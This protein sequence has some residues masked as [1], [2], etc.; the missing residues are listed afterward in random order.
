LAF[1]RDERILQCVEHFVCVRL[2]K[3]LCESRRDESQDGQLNLAH[4]AYSDWTFQLII[5]AVRDA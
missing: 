1:E 5:V 2:G 4:G 3:S